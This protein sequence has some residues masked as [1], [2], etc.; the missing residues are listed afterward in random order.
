M[1]HE[2]LTWLAERA[3]EAQT[4]VEVGCWRGR[5]TRALADHCRG[6]VYAVDPWR[7][8]YFHED[9]RTHK[10]NTDVYDEFRIN[11]ADHIESGRVVPIQRTS[12]EAWTLLV[13]RFGGAFDFV[14]LDG[15]HRY[16]TVVAEIEQ[17]RL[18]LKDGGI[19]AGHD[20]SHGDWPGVKRAVDEQFDGRVSFC[21]TIWWVQL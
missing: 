15:D 16:D 7:G 14:F 12:F 11:L 10:I 9:G 3:Q 4:I 2:E 6:T 21:R 20:Y 19:L 5:S 17:Y 1:H 13:D 8:P 18:L